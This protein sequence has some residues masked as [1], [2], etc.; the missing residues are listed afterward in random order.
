MCLSRS[1]PPSLENVVDDISAKENLHFLDVNK[2]LLDL[3]SERSIGSSS[4]STST[5][6]Y[7]AKE[8]KSEKQRECAW[9]EKRS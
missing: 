1:L 2:R 8:K 3:H 7:S 5:K 6:A 9:C 4:M